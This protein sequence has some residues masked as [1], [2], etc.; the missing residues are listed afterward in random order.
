MPGIDEIDEAILKELRKNGRATLTELGQ[1]LGL[2]PASIK[3]RMEKLKKL[4]AIKGYTAIVDPTFLD[5]FVQAII[6]VEVTSEANLDKALVSLS[7][8]DNVLSVY[9]KTGEYQILIRANFKSMKELKNFINML[10]Y[11]VFR[12][13]MRRYRVSIVLDQIKDSGVMVKRVPM[14]EERRYRRR[15]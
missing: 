6:E 10:A 2:T 13:N 14:K 11:N 15:R 8:K 7:M 5:E 4:G 3:N 9:R 12:A 1:K